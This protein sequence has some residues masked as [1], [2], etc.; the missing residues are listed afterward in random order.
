M[1]R[2]T[3]QAPQV[4]K[5]D[6]NPDQ[7]RSGIT[8]I[9]RRLDELAS[10]LGSDSLQELEQQT[11]SLTKKIDQSLSDIFGADTE[12][13]KRYKVY[14]FIQWRHNYYRWRSLERADVRPFAHTELS[15][16]P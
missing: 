10:L 1:A 2:K 5:A 15:R 4:R 8:K 3:T 16:R 13:Y 7:I 12:E 11:D 9:Q 14:N 6:L